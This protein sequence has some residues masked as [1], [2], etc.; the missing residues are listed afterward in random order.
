MS[1][2]VNGSAVVVATSPTVQLA[3][4]KSKQRVRDLA[5]VYTHE[6]EVNAMLDLVPDMFPSEVDPANHDR[7]FLEPACGSGNFLE[8]ILRRKL[9]TVTSQRYGRGQRFE[10]RV[11]RCLTSTY[12]IDIDQENVEQARR[13]LHDVLEWHL[14]SQLNTRDASTGFYAAV[15]HVL[16][17]NI[18]RANTL[19]DAATLILV[20]YQPSRGNAFLRRWSPL[21]DSEPAP[22]DLFSMDDEP[23]QDEAPVHYSLLADN[24]EPVRKKASA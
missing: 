20:D 4:I 18:V 19:T 9:V 13:R 2:V 7:R 16:E 3:Q 22:V 1:S 12:G 15:T 6:R 24:P 5:E 8:A 23:V 21:R 14:H 11:L 17:T 10:F